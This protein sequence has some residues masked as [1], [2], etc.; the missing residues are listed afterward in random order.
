MDSIAERI[1]HKKESVNLNTDKQRVSN[2]N[3]KEKNDLKK[4]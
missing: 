2:L 4:K 3:N 1:Y